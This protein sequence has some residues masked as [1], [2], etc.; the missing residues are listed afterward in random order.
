MFQTLL[1]DLDAVFAERLVHEATLGRIIDAVNTIGP[2]RH[3]MLGLSWTFRRDKKRPTFAVPLGPRWHRSL[4][5][6]NGSR[7]IVPVGRITAALAKEC[8]QHRHYRF[9]KRAD[10]LLMGVQA[11]RDQLNHTLNV[12]ARQAYTATKYAVRKRAC[13]AD[14]A[15]PPLTWLDTV[16]SEDN[17]IA[18][19]LI[20]PKAPAAARRYLLRVARSRVYA[21]T[22]L[23]EVKGNLSHL[24]HRLGLIEHRIDRYIAALHR[25]ALPQHSAVVLSWKV[26]RSRIGRNFTVMQ[27]PFFSV[28][29]YLNGKTLYFSIRRVSAAVCKSIGRSQDLLLLRRIAAALGPLRRERDLIRTRLEMARRELATVRRQFRPI[30]IPEEFADAR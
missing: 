14:L 11:R 21:E 18:E 30:P 23:E 25:R 6:R 8:F 7:Y 26:D 13:R 17:R 3:N 29:R 15:Q 10:R 20:D 16:S 27:G 22:F 4:K 28:R 1:A 12:A 2:R 24:F 5:L 19:D 9:L